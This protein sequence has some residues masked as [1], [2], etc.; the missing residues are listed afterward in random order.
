MPPVVYADVCAFQCG[1]VIVLIRTTRTHYTT[2]HNT[3]K[4]NRPLHHW[5]G[6]RSNLLT[7]GVVGERARERHL[8]AGL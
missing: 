5:T 8:H 6:R 3:T 1:D 7:D 2:Q 4:K